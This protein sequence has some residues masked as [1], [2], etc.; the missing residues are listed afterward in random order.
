M[1]RNE[2]LKKILI[3]TL[4]TGTISENSRAQYRETQY[5][6]EGKPYKKNGV[7]TKTNFVAEPIIDYF[8]PDEIFI[9]GTVKSVWHQFY[10]STITSDNSDES[11]MNDEKYNRLIQIEKNNG[12]NTELEKL[13]DLEKEITDIFGSIA[14]WEKYSPQ[15]KKRK[16]GVHILL[17][18]YGVNE[19]ELK[20][21]Y[22]ILKRIEDYLQKDV[23]YKVAFDITH[24]FRSLPI[25]NLI[26]FNYIKNITKYNIT[27]SHVYYGNIDASHELEKKA[28]IVDL[29]DLIEVLNLTNGVAEFKDTGNSVALIQMLDE[30]DDIKAVLE[31]FDLATQLNAFDKIKEELKN[32]SVLIG[33][34]SSE[35]RYT[36]IREMLGIVLG[37]RFL[38]SGNITV[39]QLNGISDMDL[40]FLLTKW[41]FNQNRMG[42]GLATGL[43]AL[44]DIN[45]PAFM[46]ARGYSSKN[47]RQY[48]ES[49]ESYFI[50]IAERIKDSDINKSE[51]ES[52]VCN[53]GKNLRRYKEIRNIFAHSL[54]N[55]DAGE[56]ASIREDIKE[57]KENLYKLKELYDRNDKNR[58]EFNRFFQPVKGSRKK[59][60]TSKFCRI[61]LDYSGNCNFNEYKKSTKKVYDVFSL[62]SS[63]QS[64]IFGQDNKKKYPTTERAFFL[65]EYLKRNLPDEYESIDIILHGC[66][67]KEDEMIFRIF[68]ECIE[69][70]RV[71][72]YYQ[73]VKKNGVSPYKDTKIAIS[74]KEQQEKFLN[75]ELRYASI[76]DKELIQV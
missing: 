45:T 57:F 11:Y 4:G 46:Q 14:S 74:L 18:Q 41:F 56:L 70:K 72:L 54:S 15:Y 47:E 75:E 36:G 42:L 19:A 58:E 69:D 10:A 71:K 51:I 73:D 53:L 27:I 22:H 21:N 60:A 76:L 35:G 9:L 12:I 64:R 6:I 7:E 66:Y 39:E 5:T 34:E 48:R 23:E 62:E 32:L 2:N 59:N 28:P 38:E 26:I 30:E 50:Q 40:K 13:E 44:R 37:E 43:E 31:R 68:L 17:T 63:V 25:Y 29:V 61:L 52:T 8:I 20:E 16:P 49:A 55:P 3:L 24:S 65:Y 1:E 67:N 33:K